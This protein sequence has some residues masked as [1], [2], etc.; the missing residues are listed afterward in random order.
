MAGILRRQYVNSNKNS[1]RKLNLLSKTVKRNQNP[2]CLQVTP[3]IELGAYTYIERSYE[4]EDN[5]DTLTGRS[6]KTGSESDA[7]SPSPPPASKLDPSVQE[8][9]KLIFDVSIMYMSPL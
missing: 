4:E 3:L 1:G 9:V 5:E 6:G 2:V 7:K 8:L